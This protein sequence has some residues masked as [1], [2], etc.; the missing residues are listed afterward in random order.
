MIAPLGKYAIP[1]R[2]GGVAALPNAGIMASR[3]GSPMA[4]PIPFSIVRRESDFFATNI[5][6]PQI[7]RSITVSRHPHPEWCATDNS[8]HDGGEFVV[9]GSSFTNNFTHSRHVMVVQT[10]SQGVGQQALGKCCRKD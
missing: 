4:V 5:N 8:H 10:T 7:K 2:R 9:F 6:S 3:K 1:K